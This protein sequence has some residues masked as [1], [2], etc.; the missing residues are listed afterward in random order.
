MWRFSC[1]TN[2][3]RTLIRFQQIAYPNTLIWYSVE[4]VYPNLKL[5][6]FMVVPLRLYLWTLIKSSFLFWPPIRTPVLPSVSIRVQ[7]GGCISTPWPRVLDV[8]HCKQ[9]LQKLDVSALFTNVHVRRDIWALT[10]S[11]VLPSVCKLLS[12]VSNVISIY[13]NSIQSMATLIIIYSKLVIKHIYDS[14][15]MLWKSFCIGHYLID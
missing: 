11:L 10:K 13:E 2:G 5:F 8:A 12:F 9:W 6:H 4:N 14:S 1:V 15:K 7:Q 3:T